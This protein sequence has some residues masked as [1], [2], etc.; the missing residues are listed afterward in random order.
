M[1]SEHRIYAIDS[2]S[3]AERLERQAQ[4]ADIEAHLKH[5]PIADASSVIDV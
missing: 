1:N 2:D 3:E 4:L 5:I